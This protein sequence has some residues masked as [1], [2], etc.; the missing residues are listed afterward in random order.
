MGV[1]PIEN[2][3]VQKAGEGDTQAV[4]QSLDSGIQPDTKDETGTTALIEAA[5]GG[6]GELVSLLLDNGAGI[7]GRD[8]KFGGT[9]LIWAALRG[10]TGR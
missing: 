6:H 7:E 10:H 3:F 4:K 2:A 1:E 9:A 8:E 5:K